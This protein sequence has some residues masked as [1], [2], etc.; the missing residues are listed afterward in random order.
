MSVFGSKSFLERRSPSAE[1][2]S[3][4]CSYSTSKTCMEKALQLENDKLYKAKWR[5]F[6]LFKQLDQDD[7]NSCIACMKVSIT[8]ARTPLR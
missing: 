7:M 5:S 4:S 3:S 1:R 2:Q 8:E 6:E